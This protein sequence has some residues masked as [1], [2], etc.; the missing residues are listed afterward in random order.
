MSTTTDMSVA[1]HYGMSQGSLLFLLKVDNFMQAPFSVEGSEI[2][3]AAGHC[4]HDLQPH[5]AASFPPLVL[6]YGADLQWISA[7][8]GEAEVLYP[9][10]TVSAAVYLR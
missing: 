1:V 4:P 6:Q 3:H 7:F 9:P 10:L 2:S 5:H 8:P